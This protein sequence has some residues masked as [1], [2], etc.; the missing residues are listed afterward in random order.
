MLRCEIVQQNYPPTELNYR[1]NDLLPRQEHKLY[2]MSV[3]VQ[4]P[5]QGRKPENVYFGQVGCFL[6]DISGT[7]WGVTACFNSKPL[8]L[9][10]KCVTDIQ[11][12][13]TVALF[14]PKLGRM[15][16]NYCLSYFALDLER[17]PSVKIAAI[18]LSSLEGVNNP[19]LQNPYVYSGENDVML[20][21]AVT[22]L[23]L[24][25]FLFHVAKRY[26]FLKFANYA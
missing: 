23:G 16:N 22:I 21:R 13:C 5:N 17:T 4:H 26:I 24:C 20:G 14:M 25:I 10:P 8:N 11:Q 19:C 15:E 1:E 6:K 3:L 9:G 12:R 2:W 7:I 18:C